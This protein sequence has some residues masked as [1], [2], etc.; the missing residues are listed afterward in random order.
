VG[1]YFEI[2][3]QAEQ[4]DVRRR[5]ATPFVPYGAKQDF[6]LDRDADLADLRIID[7]YRD[8]KPSR[9]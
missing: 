2:A 5:G 9:D 1:S 7:S 8:P 4:P 3:E 6:R